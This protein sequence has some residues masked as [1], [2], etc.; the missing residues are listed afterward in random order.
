MEHAGLAG[1]EIPS[2]EDQVARAEHWRYVARDAERPVN[3]CGGGHP[4]DDVSVIGH[5]DFPQHPGVVRRHVD[6][7]AESTSVL[8]LNL[9]V[10]Q[11][12]WLQEP[13]RLAGEVAAPA[14]ET[15]MATVLSERAPARVAIASV[16]VFMVF[17]LSR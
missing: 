15:P 8:T 5:G 2:P 11:T 14:A 16:L 9:H 13:F 1:R 17:S 6:A 10:A 3:L 7:D 12:V 4:H